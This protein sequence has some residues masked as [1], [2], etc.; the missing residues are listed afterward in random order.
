[1]TLQKEIPY[2][3]EFKLDLREVS[4]LDEARIKLLKLKGG[5]LIERKQ[6]IKKAVESYLAHSVVR[7]S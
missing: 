4:K 6:F 5:S 1:M 2:Q 3:F 7:Q